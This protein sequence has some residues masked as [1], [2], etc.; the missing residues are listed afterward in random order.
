MLEKAKRKGS[1]PVVHKY[2]WFP[3]PVWRNSE[4][5]NS[6]KFAG[7]PPQIYVVP[8]LQFSNNKKTISLILHYNSTTKTKIIIK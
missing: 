7:V 8:L 3:Y 5:L 1:V 2:V 4:V 6:A